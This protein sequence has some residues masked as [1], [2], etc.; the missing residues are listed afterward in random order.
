VAGSGNTRLRKS[1]GKVI[2][3]IKN[4]TLVKDNRARKIFPDVNSMKVSEAI[5]L[6]L[7]YKQLSPS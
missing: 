2:L 3:S 5:S 6:A 7:S 1:S 4:P